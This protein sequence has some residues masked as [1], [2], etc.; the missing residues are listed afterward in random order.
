LNK[1]GITLT[2]LSL[3]FVNQLPFVT[4]NIIGATKMSQL[5]ENIGSIHIN[6]SEETLNE[7]EAVHA[8]IPNPAP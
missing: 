4:S 7:I 6:L 8:A 5:K 1:N 3:A 2:Q